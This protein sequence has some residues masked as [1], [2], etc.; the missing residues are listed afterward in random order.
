MGLLYFC[1]VFWLDFKTENLNGDLSLKYF[2]LSSLN[3]K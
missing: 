3:L 1:L 2:F